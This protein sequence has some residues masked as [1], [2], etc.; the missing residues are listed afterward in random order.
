MEH[1][2]LPPP[3]GG[4]VTHMIERDELIR[5]HDIA[6]DANRPSV[7]FSDDPGKEAYVELLLAAYKARGEVLNKIAC[8]LSDVLF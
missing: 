7:K 4:P 8:F 5:L 3:S 2:H 6:T 1:L